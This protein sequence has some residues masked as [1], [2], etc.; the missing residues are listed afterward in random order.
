[1]MR[2]VDFRVDHIFQMKNY[3]KQEHLALSIDE[4]T[5]KQLDKRSEGITILK[6]NRAI[7]C[8]GAV[9]INNF[10]ASIWALFEQGNPRDFVFVHKHTYRFIHGLKFNRIES[11]VDPTNPAAV[12]WMELLGLKLEI[13]YT[14]YFFP[15]GS[16]AST[17]VLHK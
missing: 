10:R 7:A 2:C 4:D 16:G 15:D 9:R 13:A 3:D 11:Y 12:R 14:P 1:M 17:W 8:G 5:L 6:D